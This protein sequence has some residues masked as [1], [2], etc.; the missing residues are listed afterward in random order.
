MLT[1]R[2]RGLTLMERLL[3]QVIKTDACWLWAGY[4]TGGYGKIRTGVAQERVHRVMWKLVHG[5]IPKGM[6][7]R[8]ACDVPNCVNPAHLSLGTD[9]DNNADM[10]ERGRGVPLHGVRNGMARLNDEIVRAIRDDANSQTAIAEM[11]S[12]SQVHVSRIKSRK[13]WAHV[14]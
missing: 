5:D 13:S 4:T 9:A 8:H 10:R 12:I 3:E 1:K 6:L 14:V 11:H 7:V 2:Q